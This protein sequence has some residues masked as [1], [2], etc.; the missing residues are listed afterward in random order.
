VFQSFTLSLL[1]FWER[2]S[3]KKKRRKEKE[4]E[5]KRKKTKKIIFSPITLN[6]DGIGQD[7]Y[8]NTLSRHVDN[9]PGTHRA[10]HSNICSGWRSYIKINISDFLLHV[11]HTSYFMDHTTS[12]SSWSMIRH[13]VFILTVSSNSWHSFLFFFL[14][15][16]FH[17]FTLFIVW[18]VTLLGGSISC[19]DFVDTWFEAPFFFFFPF[20]FLS[21]FFLM[22]PS[23]LHLFTWLIGNRLNSLLSFFLHFFKSLTYFFITEIVT[24]ETLIVSWHWHWNDKSP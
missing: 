15:T 11:H 2:I 14:F 21:F 16:F 9:V 24:D 5:K 13:D 8:E 1:I 12:Y 22:R 23:P 6:R 3:K 4:K 18:V 10:H 7:H 19:F 20:Q 17:F